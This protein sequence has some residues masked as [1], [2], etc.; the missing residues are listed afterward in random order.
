VEE[1]DEEWEDLGE[2]V[3]KADRSYAQVVEGS[4]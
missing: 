3:A 1:Y 2:D 4:R